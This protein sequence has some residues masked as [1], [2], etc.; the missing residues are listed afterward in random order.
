MFT[1]LIQTGSGELLGPIEN[2]W[3]EMVK[4]DFRGNTVTLG[5]TSALIVKENLTLFKSVPKLLYCGL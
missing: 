4:G 1:E 5:T 2:L 3:L